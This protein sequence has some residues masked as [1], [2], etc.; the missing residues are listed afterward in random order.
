M[1]V[2]DPDMVRALVRDRAADFLAPFIHG[3]HSVSEAAARL[4]ESVQRTHYWVRSLYDAGVL[5][6]ASETPRKGRAIKRYRAIATEFVIPAQ[7]LPYD[8]FAR[9]MHRVNDELTRALVAAAPAWVVSGDLRI[10]A[11][12]P[13]RGTRALGDASPGPPKVP[14]HQS[15]AGL[16]LTR[17][18]ALQL[19][20]E[21]RQL[22]DR[23]I[24]RSDDESGEQLYLA[25]LSF[26]PI[27]SDD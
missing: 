25:S 11:P 8:Y 20:T 19:V 14:A 10:H 24:A 3:E 22:Q 18:D 15:S 12:T 4:D 21:I 6:I 13:E 9:G 2:T 17:A 1:R 27:P 7:A 5:E 16:R 23:W 26:A